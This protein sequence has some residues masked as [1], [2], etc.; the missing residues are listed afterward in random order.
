LTSKR[1]LQQDRFTAEARRGGAE[2]KESRTRVYS[3]RFLSV[4]CV[5]AVKRSLRDRLC[6]ESTDAAQFW[7]HHIRC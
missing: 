4:L 3:L 6:G 2:K 1:T 5:S 7:P